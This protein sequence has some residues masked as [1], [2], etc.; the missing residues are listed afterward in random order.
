ME[1]A[2]ADHAESL[3]SLPQSMDNGNV[4]DGAGR[5]KTAYHRGQNL[6]RGPHGMIGRVRAERVRRKEQER[7]LSMVEETEAL[8]GAAER[9]RMLQAEVAAEGG[10]DEE[11]GLS[12]EEQGHSRGLIGETAQE[13]GV[14]FNPF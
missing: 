12:L 14:D 5:Y 4:R 2:A 10:P 9:A 3:P 13:D 8:A 6:L 1:A 11:A 7:I